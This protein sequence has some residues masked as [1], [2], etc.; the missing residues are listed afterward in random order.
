MD[1]S[2]DEFNAILAT[3]QIAF[4]EKC[5]NTV[6]PGAA[7]MDNWH[8]HC[9]V[10]HLQAVERG[11]ISR[12]IINMPPRSL[13]SMCVSIAWP[14]WLL[15]H[16]PETQIMVG[17]FKQSLSNTLSMDCRLV[18]ESEWYRNIFPN[19]MLAP[20]QNEKSKFKTTRRGHRLATTAGSAPTGEGGDYLILDDPIAPPQKGE[21]PSLGIIESTNTWIS[22]TFLSRFNDRRSGRAVLVMQ[23]LH[24]K[25]PTAYLMDKGS[26]HTLILPAKFRE[27]TII[28][29]GE[30]MWTIEEGEYL[31]EERL[32]KAELHQALEDLTPYGFSGQMLQRP[33]PIGGGEFKAAWLQ[34]YDNYSKNFTAKG[35]NIYIL[36]DPANQK[37]NKERSEPDYTAIVVVGLAADNNYYILDLVRDRL[38]PTERIEKLMFMHRKWNKKG[39]KPPKV[40]CEQY[41]MMTDSF[42]LKKRQDESNYRFKVIEVGGQVKKEDR[43][44]KLIP[45]FESERV[46]LP[47]KVLYDNVEGKTIELV[48]VFIEDELTV[49]PVG[50]HDDMIDAFA[51]IMED[52]VHATFPKE[53]V[54]FLE[55]GQSKQDYLQGTFRDED[56]STW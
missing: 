49:F 45:I 30:K 16:R 33:T 21:Q 9:I 39:G 36:Y 37:K 22:Q 25:D 34:F 18:I 52:D 2:H 10:E 48:K 3:D 51:R 1:I 24:E 53:E 28:T 26:W 17:S 13:K 55:A 14:A 31:H 42:Y 19:T 20:D 23:R 5:F 8:I 7:Y 6:S 12:L 41:G 38:N 4:T 27:R 50:K 47:R 46:M 32:G 29:I 54:L 15:G 35:M 56:F 44:R 11:E 40:V 43:I